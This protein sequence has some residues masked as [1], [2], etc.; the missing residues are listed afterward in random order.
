MQTTKPLLTIYILSYNS[1]EKTGRILDS[2]LPFTSDRTCVIVGDN[3]EANDS[4]EV[5]ESRKHHFNGRLKYVKHICNLG[6][7]GSALRA[8]EMA[9]SEYLWL[10]GC[11]DQ[12][13][14]S[15]I[16][17]VES[18]LTGLGPN[19]VA[20]QVNDVKSGEWPQEP[21][22]YK[23]FIPA[24]ID[25][26][27]G[28]LTNINNVIYPVEL[29]RKF[30][31]AAYEA[32]SSLVPQTAILAAGI[33]EETEANLHYFPVQVFQRL[34]RPQAWDVRKLWGNLATIY[35]DFE[36]DKRWL[37]VRRI[38]DESHSEWVVSRLK[39]LNLPV[40]RSFITRT[41]GQFGSKSLPLYIKL[42]S[43]R[44]EQNHREYKNILAFSQ[45]MIGLLWR[46]RRL[47][48]KVINKISSFK[49]P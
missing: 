22:I 41:F 11:G 37:Q 32:G 36:D 6:F 48:T 3:S 14:P 19:F 24:L 40:T 1:P 25:L 33:R 38:V 28:P 44:W 39:A 35:P 30:L 26:D 12:F 7:I 20:F 34:P 23:D 5:T 16:A 21:K 27:L 42:L 10:V 31:P 9:D 45:R 43:L 4:S 49:K 15:T 2:L 13:L 47:S 29:S 17:D 18:I 46:V 8:F